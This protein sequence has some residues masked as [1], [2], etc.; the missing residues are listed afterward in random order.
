VTD[1]RSTQARI[2][3]LTEVVTEG[4]ENLTWTDFGSA[5][6]ELARLVADSGFDPEIVVAIAR[7]G[8][9]LGGSIA[10]ALGVKACGALNV[11]FYTGVGTVLEAPVVL[12]PFLDESALVGKRVLLADDVADS[13]RTLDLVV[14]MLTAGGSEVR[15]VC[16]YSKPR[17]VLEPEF[18]WKRTDACINFPWSVLPPVAPLGAVAPGRDA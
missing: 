2:D 13:G 3:A 4:R 1:A 15:S 11:E 10:Y 14:R 12:P 16:L 17:T 18:V 7:G 8:L 5:T 6:R 9:L